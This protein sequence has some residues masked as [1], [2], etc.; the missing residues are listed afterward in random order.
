MII[1]D[2][3]MMKL[4]DKVTEKILKAHRKIDEAFQEFDKNLGISISVK[5]TPSKQMAGVLDMKTE[6]K[7]YTGQYVD[8]SIDQLYDKQ[9]PMF[10]GDE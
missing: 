3:H 6:L 4:R 10:P 7:F 2:D 8:S 1:T 5:I 9:I